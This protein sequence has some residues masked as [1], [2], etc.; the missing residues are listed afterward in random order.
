M[1]ALAYDAAKSLGAS[2]IEALVITG[3]ADPN[4]L[5]KITLHYHDGEYLSG[6]TLHGEE[7]Q[8][9][10]QIGLARY[11]SGWGYHVEDA[12]VN[13]LG[14]EFLYHQALE[15]AR[16]AIEAKKS[17]EAA[18]KAIRE[19]AFAVAA[20]TGKPVVLDSYT[21]ECNDPRE[22]CSLDNVTVY[23]M[24]DGSTKT[25]RSHTW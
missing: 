12:V 13:A 7:T 6:Y 9:L 1:I 4:S 24:P 17:S 3:E 2:E 21:D 5:K 23:A 25:S 20:R 18:E 11:V 16:P 22:E 14:T 8:L 15:L 19:N 10:E